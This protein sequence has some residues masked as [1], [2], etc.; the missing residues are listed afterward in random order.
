MAPVMAAAC[1]TGGGIDVGSAVGS[2]FLSMALTAIVGIAV[3]KLLYMIIGL[4]VRA[5]LKKVNIYSFLNTK[6]HL[7]I[8]VCMY[9]PFN[10]AIVGIAVG[11]LL[12]MIIGLPVRAALKKVYIYSSLNTFSYI[13]ICMCVYLPLADAGC[14]RWHRSGE[15]IQN[16]HRIDDTIFPVRS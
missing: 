6:L 14:N 7:C 10:A 5:A 9:L 16:D 3:G 11:K 13:Y 2:F 1:N 12:Y 8:C 15:A 4:P